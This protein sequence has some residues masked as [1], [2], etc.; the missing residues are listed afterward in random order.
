MNHD[1]VLQAASILRK[2]WECCTRIDRLPPECRP[3]DR[4][5][6]YAIQ[7]EMLRQ[8]G[9]QSI[10]WKIAATS[11]AGQAHIGVD[12]PLAGRLWSN[13]VL[14]N[15][16]TISLQGNAMRV[17]EAEFAFQMGRPLP[18][19]ASAY[20]VGEVIDAASSLYIGME[21]PDSRYED[22]AQ[23]GMAQLIADNA[24]ASWYILGEEVTKQWRERNLVS[25]AVTVLRNGKVTARGDGSAVLGDP[26]LA[27]A[28]I[29]NELSMFGDGLKPGEIVT[30][31]T[32]IQPVE[33]REGDE[34]CLNFGDFGEVLGRF[35]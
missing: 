26:R 9:H 6:A 20:S 33:V 10:G 8:S 15:G 13:R 2:H 31:G 1:A 23:A 24:C 17:I 5:S 34:V 27:L 18:P 19:R 25:H 14:G 11:A 12:G 3:R 32:C 7:A 21:I 22:F 28:W 4:A 29:A 35:V 30:T 16:S